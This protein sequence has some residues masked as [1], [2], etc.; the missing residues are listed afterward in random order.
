MSSEADNGG[1][2]NFLGVL[3]HQVG[4]S[5][6]AVTL[7]G[8]AI[9]KYTETAAAYKKAL[10]LSPVFHMFKYESLIENMEKE[11][12]QPTDFLGI[13]R[14]DNVLDEYTSNSSQY[15]SRL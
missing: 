12:S 2:N 15:I 6:M 13:P 1:A 3:Q 14:D 11:L 4:K 9:D 5:D 8:K 7:I 10:S